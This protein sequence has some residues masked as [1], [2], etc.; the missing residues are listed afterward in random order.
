MK[1]TTALIRHILTALIPCRSGHGMF[2]PSLGPCPVCERPV[3][4]PRA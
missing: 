1:H 2:D 3:Y 4:T